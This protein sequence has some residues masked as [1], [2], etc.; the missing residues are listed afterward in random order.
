MPIRCVS[1]AA[2]Y[3][4]RVLAMCCRNQSEAPVCIA[5]EVCEK[6]YVPE[7]ADHIEHL[8]LCAAFLRRYSAYMHAHMH[9]CVAHMHACII[10]IIIII[11]INYYYHC[12]EVAG[13]HGNPCWI[14][15]LQ[16]YSVC[17]RY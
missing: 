2:G 5:M 9:M 16:Y 4:L 12:A 17:G 7:A 1:Q 14:H 10:I 11:I 15:V 13:L 3:A 6:L 8:G